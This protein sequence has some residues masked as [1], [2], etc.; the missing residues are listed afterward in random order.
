MVPIPSMNC[1]NYL[2]SL[3][4]KL[5]VPFGNMV[6]EDM[7]NLNAF[8]SPTIPFM[9]VK[10][11]SLCGCPCMHGDSLLMFLSMKDFENMSARR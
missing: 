6:S 9:M 8:A 4:C 7:W 11:M 3:Q 1:F 5:L 10:N 2:T